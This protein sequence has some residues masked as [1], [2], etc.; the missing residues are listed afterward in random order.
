MAVR[1]FWT[2]FTVNKPGMAWYVSLDRYGPEDT[3]FRFAV[4]IKVL[5]GSSE[6]ARKDVAWQ[7]VARCLVHASVLIYYSFVFGLFKDVVCR[8]DCLASNDRMI[9]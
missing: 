5:S 4:G 7:Q 1:F 3:G 2:C 9:N 8:S 6:S